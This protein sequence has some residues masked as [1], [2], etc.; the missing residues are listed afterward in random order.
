MGHRLS[1]ITTRTGDKGTTGLA[2]GARVQ[3]DSPRVIALGAVDELNSW[4]GVVL[5]HDLPPQARECLV[6]VQQR[7]F[8][9]GAQL[10]SP[11]HR[12]MTE[13][14]ILAMERRVE[15]FNAGLEPLKEFILPGGSPAA[16]FCHVART[17]CRRAETRV[18]ALNALEP[19]ENDALGPFLNRLSDLLFVLARVLNKAAGTA[20]PMWQP[21]RK[22]L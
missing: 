2:T 1:K 8:E 21:K 12:R 11:G 20:E 15:A 17:V 16:S 3:K 10:S 5:A 13:D 18:V 22:P 9:A 7:L 14:D 19:L 6:D 4:L